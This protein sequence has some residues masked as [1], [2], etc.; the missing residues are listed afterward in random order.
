MLKAFFTLKLKNKQV[1]KLKGEMSI[2]RVCDDRVY[3]RRI[4]SVVHSFRK[5]LR[6]IRKKHPN[7]HIV[8][9]HDLS[10]L[11]NPVERVHR[12]PDVDE[13]LS[14]FVSINKNPDKVLSKSVRLTGTCDDI[15]EI[16]CAMGN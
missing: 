14:W 12:I 4:T 6:K 5:T 11:Y 2:N 13:H 1:L 7:A 15:M 8:V 9:V 10:A 16:T 3:Y